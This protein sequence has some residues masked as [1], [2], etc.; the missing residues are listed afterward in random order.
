MILQMAASTTVANSLDR[1][2]TL[3]EMI[4]RVPGGMT[5]REIRRQ[6]GIPKSSYSYLMSHL[7]QRGYVTQDAESR[8]YKIGL[9]P[10][11]L[12]CGSLREMDFRSVTEPILYRLARETGLAASIGVLER[13]RVLLV[14]RVESPQFIQEVVDA[15]HHIGNSAPAGHRRMRQ[16]REI[17]RELPA[18]SNALG[19]VLLASRSREEVLEI[20]ACEGLPAL[21]PKT[22]IL[23]EHLL[24]VLEAI[25]RQGYA[26][27]DEEHYASVRA[28]GA[29]ILDANGAV[30]AALSATGNPASP[31]W[32]E[33]PN[34][35]ELVKAA[36]RDI[37]R[38]MRL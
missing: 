33:L 37:S 34:L 24:V 31:A 9:T 3:L 2:L 17:G 20:I 5:S 12:A 38:S 22:I 13:G 19:K 23:P 15:A 6:L 32:K 25:R 26:I 28:V 11:V 4:E 10:L 14:D 7:R 18:H 30:C 29:P 16:D 21:T 1:A 36:G 8:R 35:I 27:S